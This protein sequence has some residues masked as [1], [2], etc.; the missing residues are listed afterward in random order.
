MLTPDTLDTAPCNTEVRGPSPNSRARCWFGTLNNYTEEEFNYLEEWL[1]I[2]AIDYA[3]QEEIGE[4]GTPHIQFCMKFKNARYFNSMKKKLPKAHFEVCKNWAASRSYCLKDDTHNGRRRELT[5]PKIFDPLESVELHDWQ[6]DICQ[7]MEETPDNR[8]IYWYWENVGCVGKTTLARHL[9]LQ[10]PNQV[11]YLSGK[12][13]DILYGVYS[14]LEEDENDLRMVILDFSRSLENYISWD[15]IE[16]LKNG[17]FYNTKYK[18]AMCVFNYIHVV[19]FANFEPPF[20]QLSADRW[21]IINIGEE[22]ELAD[23]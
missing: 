21:K 15:A 17:I 19:C 23:L 13:A 2:D 18:S 22:E 14:F 3:F 1:K 8:T 6:S 20:T 12:K 4:N 7:L 16:S 10:Y 5:K 11:L 9:C